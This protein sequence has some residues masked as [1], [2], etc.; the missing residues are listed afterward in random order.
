MQ[1]SSSAFTM[2]FRRIFA[3]VWIIDEQIDKDMQGAMNQ[4]VAAVHYHLQIQDHS[5][6]RLYQP[7]E[8]R[9][10][11]ISQSSGA[12]SNG[13]YPGLSGLFVCNFTIMLWVIS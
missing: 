8:T 12:H 3:K 1:Y 13:K 4:D 6:P 11:Q 7:I 10:K 9:C 5:W 2:P